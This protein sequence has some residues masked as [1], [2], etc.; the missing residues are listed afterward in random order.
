MPK[1]V[2]RVGATDAGEERREGGKK[3]GGEE[4]EMKPG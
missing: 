3:E 4:G 1:V 2:L